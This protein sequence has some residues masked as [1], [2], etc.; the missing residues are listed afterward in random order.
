MPKGQEGE[1]QE[2]TW[3]W[4]PFPHRVL[5]QPVGSVLLQGQRQQSACGR[6]VALRYDPPTLAGRPAPP[7]LT[8]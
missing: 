5:Q 2:K 7:F 4:A 8:R 3:F 6:L 1:A